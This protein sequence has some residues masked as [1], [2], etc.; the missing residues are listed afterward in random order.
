MKKVVFFIAVIFLIL[1]SFYVKADDTELKLAGVKVVNDNYFF[2]DEGLTA[3]RGDNIVIFP[4]IKENN[5]YKVVCSLDGKN[6]VSYV[7]LNG[8]T[9]QISENCIPQN[10]IKVNYYKIDGYYHYDLSK[11]D[12]SKCGILYRN[13]IE[14]KDY[15][16]YPTFPLIYSNFINY[17]EGEELTHLTNGEKNLIPQTCDDQSKLCIQNL[18]LILINQ[19][20]KKIESEIGSEMFYNEALRPNPGNWGT[21]RL[22]SCI[23]YKNQ[24]ICSKGAFYENEPCGINIDEYNL[25][26]G[27]T[28]A[29]RFSLRSSRDNE[30]TSKGYS[31]KEIDFLNNVEAYFGFNGRL[32]YGKIDELNLNY[33]LPTTE[34]TIKYANI[35]CGDL[36]WGARL[37]AEKESY[38][39][40]QNV[41]ATAFYCI[42]GFKEE[43]V[44]CSNVGSYT[45]PVNEWVKVVLDE[46]SLINFFYLDNTVYLLKSSPIRMWIERYDVSS[47][48]FNKD[49]KFG[50]DIVFTADG[51]TP[52]G[53][54]L[55]YMNDKI[56]ESRSSEA[57]RLFVEKEDGIERYYL[58]FPFG[59][60][61]EGVY[62]FD[63][64]GQLSWYQVI[65]KDS[66]PHGIFVLN[67][68]VYVLTEGWS[69]DPTIYIFNK[70]SGEK[71]KEFSINKFS[72]KFR[73]MDMIGK[74]ED[75]LINVY[76]LCST[77]SCTPG[78]DC[79]PF[80]ALFELKIDGSNLEILNEKKIS[81]KNEE[82]YYFLDETK[83]VNKIS[84]EILD[85]LITNE[86][87]KE[88]SFINGKLYTITK[89]LENY[90]LYQLNINS[91]TVDK[92]IGPFS[93]ILKQNNFIYGISNG[94]AVL[95]LLPSLRETNFIFWNGEGE[96]LHEN[97]ELSISTFDEENKILTLKRADNGEE[98]YRTTL[99]ENVVDAF[100]IK[101]DTSNLVTVEDS[102]NSFKIKIYSISLKNT[103]K[104]L[105]TEKWSSQEYPKEFAGDYIRKNIF[106]QRAL[107][108]F[109]TSKIILDVSDYS[110]NDIL[111]NFEINNIK[112]IGND[113]SDSVL[114]NDYT[115]LVKIKDN[116]CYSS[117][118]DELYSTLRF[119]DNNLA[120]L[121]GSWNSYDLPNNYG[122]G[123][124][125][126]DNS[127]IEIKQSNTLPGDS[128]FLIFK[129]NLISDFEL[130]Q[131]CKRTDR[132]WAVWK[133]GETEPTEQEIT[134]G[135]GPNDVRIGDLLMHSTDAKILYLDVDPVG[136]L[137]V[138]D[139]YVGG[140]GGVHYD[141]I[142][143]GVSLEL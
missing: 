13:K 76:A 63:N 112:G 119:D 1:L 111:C 57:T 69:D 78:V 143:G 49:K 51:S 85:E 140:Y 91:R 100:Y 73:C 139:I 110:I 48:T 108:S 84:K 125:N 18:E 45:E 23:E 94:N 67:D 120:F 65:G 72:N 109:R 115:S 40:L 22:Y 70:I 114:I 50:E 124:M 130:A 99:S 131:T 46:D 24:V 47:G 26:T 29:F 5:E 20:G 134:I 81:I 113:N 82:Y 105:L 39:N 58:T 95:Y 42:N 136:I 127:K 141:A 77:Q 123:I 92:K 34:Q 15:T 3:D 79:Y 88:I 129:N 25:E 66:D 12:G 117:T 101:S 62:V 90:Y 102:G 121:F 33:V 104:I 37:N 64:N 75:G 44:D 38:L 133:E 6:W 135:H 89:N 107:L 32:A 27:A 106:N 103:K 56:K 54:F 83:T 7:I 97:N 98:Y 59:D 68:N 80:N 132:V 60:D 116:Q 4:L 87:I 17:F 35:D 21:L 61:Y 28:S 11:F 138:E 10:E 71:V 30:L 93:M 19:L 8:E 96:I 43:A 31:A 14:G 9:I 118:F 122:I 2:S 52:K 53:N 86:E 16:K 126:L 74:P 36:L 128:N 55:E 137:N 142:M 41:G